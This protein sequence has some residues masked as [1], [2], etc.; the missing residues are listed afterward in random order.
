MCVCEQYIL[1]SNSA[2]KKRHEEKLTQQDWLTFIWADL[3]I[4]YEKQISAAIIMIMTNK[5]DKTEMIVTPNEI[6]NIT[7][8]IKQI[9]NN[10]V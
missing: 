3:E 1:F 9:T 10:D 6:K 4:K 8:N 5:S 7:G 2:D